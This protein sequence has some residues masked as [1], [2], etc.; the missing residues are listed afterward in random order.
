LYLIFCLLVFINEIWYIYYDILK[1]ERGNENENGIENDILI[2]KN[3]IIIW[4]VSTL[5]LIDLC[6][7]TLPPLI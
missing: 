1:R 3:Y 2:K 6:G 4:G 5:S 7:K